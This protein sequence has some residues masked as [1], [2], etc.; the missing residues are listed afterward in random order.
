VFQFFQDIL[1]YFF[2]DKEVIRFREGLSTAERYMRWGLERRRRPDIERALDSASSLIDEKSNGVEKLF[3]KY[4]VIG[5]SHAVLSELAQDEFESRKQTLQSEAAHAR[6]ERQT[7]AEKILLL[8]QQEH[9]FRDEGSLIN[10]D[11]LRQQI[12]ELGR[13]QTAPSDDHEASVRALLK[14]HGERMGAILQRLIAVRDVIQSMT[15]LPADY[16]V[17]RKTFM[18]KMAIAIAQLEAWAETWL[19]NDAAPSSAAVTESAAPGPA[20]AG[21]PP[22]QS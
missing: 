21:S 14:E 17:A 7:N 3:R 9:K 5:T 8:E 18:E 11:Q 13:S 10:A 22:A 20:G 15:D 6:N 16:E 12:E 4:V 1:S 19:Q 2:P